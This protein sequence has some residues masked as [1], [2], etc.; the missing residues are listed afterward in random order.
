VA[1]GEDVKNHINNNVN[2]TEIKWDPLYD[3]LPNSYEVFYKFINKGKRLEII[4]LFART[5]F[6]T[7]W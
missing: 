7:M 1:K 6:W 2:V 5:Y 3:N 4:Y